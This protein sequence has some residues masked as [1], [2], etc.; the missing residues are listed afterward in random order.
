MFYASDPVWESFI[1]V[2]A[3]RNFSDRCHRSATC[4]IK[5][6]EQ[7]QHSHTDPA[8]VTTPSTTKHANSDELNAN[9]V[10][11]FFM[12]AILP[13]SSHRLN[14]GVRYFK[15]GGASTS[16]PRMKGLEPRVQG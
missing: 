10:L 15:E 6:N 16:S 13:L 8:P 2:S 11:A 14:I 9:R 12:T 1:V 3:S 7:R 4:N 5:I